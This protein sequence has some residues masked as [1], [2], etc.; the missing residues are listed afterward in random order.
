[1]K[2]KILFFGDVVGKIGR[3]ALTKVVPEYRE[4]YDPDLMLLNVENLAHGKG[5][6]KKT[7]AEMEELGFDLFTS[8]NHIWRKKEVGDIVMEE[9]SK[10]LRPANYPPNVPGF[11]HKV[12][13][14]GTKKVLV[15]NLIG[16]VFFTESFDCPF[17]KFDEIFEQLEKDWPKFAAVIVDFHAE[18]TSEKNALGHY[19]DGR[20]SAVMGTHTHIGTADQKILKEGTGYVSDIGMIGA[21]DSVIGVDKENVIKM[22]LDSVN[23]T[24]EIP[25]EGKAVINAV[26]LEVDPKTKKTT[27]I[28][29][30]D[31]ETTV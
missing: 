14:V 4:Q 30:A 12:I 22:F 20:A 2:L 25:E 31:K 29:R 7:L 19:L 16:R 26:Y 5:V 23:Y 10:V 11:G 15:I 8:G 21:L 28:E 27:K 17:R 1:M 13:D 24:F 18:A 3:A 9:G 6:T